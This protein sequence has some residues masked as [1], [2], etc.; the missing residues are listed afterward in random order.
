MAESIEYSDKKNFYGILYEYGL[1]PNDI[2]RIEC[3]NYSLKDIKQNPEILNELF[4]PY[5]SEEILKIKN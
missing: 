3:S 4:E 5:Q 1:N 2:W